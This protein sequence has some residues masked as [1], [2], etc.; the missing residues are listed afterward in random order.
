MFKAFDKVTSYFNK[1][2][3]DYHIV[4]KENQMVRMCLQ[5]DGQVFQVV[6]RMGELDTVNMT[7]IQTLKI[8]KEKMAEACVLANKIN[9][10]TIATFTIDQNGDLMT[11]ISLPGKC[12]KI[13]AKALRCAY[14]RSF[15]DALKYFNAF[16]QLAFGNMLPEEAY[17][18]VPEEETEEFKIPYIRMAPL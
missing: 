1:E 9:T 17:S 16:Y 12:S 2:H 3:Q 11:T 18:C 15:K 4:D 8:P 7:V 5:G 6:C 13:T 10:G 14:L